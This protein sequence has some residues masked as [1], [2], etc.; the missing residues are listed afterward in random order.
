MSIK[1]GRSGAPGTLLT[2]AACPICFPTLAFI[3][4]MAGFGALA[5]YEFYFYIVFQVLALVTF[6]DVILSNRKHRDSKI[7]ILASISIVLFFF[8]LYFFVNEYLSY[9][10][11][12]GLVVSVAWQFIETRHCRA[13]YL[14]NYRTYNRVKK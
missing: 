4:A 5:E 13:I 12:A 8:S 3:G 14:E 11:L 10:A 2:A 7:L 1:P 9:I 6:A